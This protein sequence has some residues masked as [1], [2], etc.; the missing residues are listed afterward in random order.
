MIKMP[1][2]PSPEK[3]EAKL[4]LRVIWAKDDLRFLTWQPLEGQLSQ[5]LYYSTLFTMLKVL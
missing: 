1:G 4:L 3:D 5:E 2:P